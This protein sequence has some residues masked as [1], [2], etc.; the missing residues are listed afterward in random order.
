ME[1]EGTRESTTAKPK[2]K[3]IQVM[4]TGRLFSGTVAMQFY[5]NITGSGTLQ[6]NNRRLIGCLKSVICSAGFNHDRDR[7]SVENPKSKSL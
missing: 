5:C 1:A 3:E 6:L 7:G 4:N 2:T